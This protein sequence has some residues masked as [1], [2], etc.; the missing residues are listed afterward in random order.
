MN[1]NQQL[2]EDMKLA[3]K[4]RDQ[5]KLDTVRFLRSA[6][7]NWEIDHGAA[8][9]A[10][11][12]KIIATQIKQV[13]ES[14]EGYL[15]GGSEDRAN[16]EKSKLDILEGYLPT[17]LTDEEL[18]AIVTEAIAQAPSKDLGPIIGLAMKKVAG[19]A[20]GG[21][22]SALVKTLLSA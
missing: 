22:V 19:K 1:L 13:K 21:R 11:I 8:S 20:D 4:S 18:R 16:E 12:H 14:I 9:D 10:D 2:M 17:Q 7:K 6:V 15:Q 3:M 5:I